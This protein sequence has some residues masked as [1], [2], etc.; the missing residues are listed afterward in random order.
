MVQASDLKDRETLKKISITKKLK[1]KI[2]LGNAALEMIILETDPG[3]TKYNEIIYETAKVMTA[4]FQQEFKNEKDKE[5]EKEINV[6]KEDRERNRI[7][8]R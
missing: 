6:E 5:Q 1:N 8:A 3:L 2:E 7:Y 4:M